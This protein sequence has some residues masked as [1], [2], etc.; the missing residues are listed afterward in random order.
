MSF[1]NT[2]PHDLHAEESM[3]AT[4]CYRPDLAAEIG[5]T[6]HPEDFYRPDHQAVWAAF[7]YLQRSGSRIDA[8]T[9]YETAKDR[10]GYNGKATTLLVDTMTSTLAMSH[11]V[12]DI[13]L[14]HKASRDLLALCAD[15]ISGIKNRTDPFDLA[16][17]LSQNASILG[18]G[19][20]KEPESVPF[21]ALQG[22]SD[23]EGRFIIPEVI[24]DDAMALIIA[25]EGLGKATWLRQ[26]GMCAA[27]GVHPFTRRTMEPIRVLYVDLENPLRN[28][29]TP[30][31]RL[32]WTLMRR[33]GDDYDRDRL[34]FWRK[35]S[36]INILKGRDMGSLEREIAAFRPNL[37]IIGPLAKLYRR[38]SHRDSYEDVADR[39]IDRLTHLRAK[40][41]F[42]L[43]I[44]HHAPKGR[45]SGQRHL[46]P[47]GSQRWM[48]TPDLG[49]TM[50]PAKDEPNRLE[51]GRFRGDRFEVKWPDFIQRDPDWVFT[52][53]YQ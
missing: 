18:T 23:T 19:T 52:A 32:Q 43:L 39:V 29:I 10:F 4:A 35:K 9:L 3:M 42:G 11:D 37:V 30:T 46:D 15:T 51:I 6:L 13:I 1:D 41:S 17:E 31:T 24:T 27:Q 40:Y 12:V 26:I 33:L 38:D 48:G 5:R 14:R 22:M 44:E 49:I 21:E 36:G 20:R 25:E 47:M 16:G 34:K 8:L 2:I 28:I 50:R 7:Q 53:V 45:E